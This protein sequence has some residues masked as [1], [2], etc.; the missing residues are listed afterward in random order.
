MAIFKRLRRFLGIEK[1][2]LKKR[3]PSMYVSELDL[4]KGFMVISD[5][6]T[7]EIINIDL[8]NQKGFSTINN[9]HEKNH[10]N[11]LSKSCSDIHNKIMCKAEMRKVC[12]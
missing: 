5:I 10:L 3:I 8:Y 4:S 7:N 12:Y 11:R 1:N 6:K 2:R 9:N